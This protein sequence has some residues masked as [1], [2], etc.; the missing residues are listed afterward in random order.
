MWACS[1][2]MIRS[3]I[4]IVLSGVTAQRVEGGELELLS[5]VAGDDDQLGHAKPERLDGRLVDVGK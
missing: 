4:W 1:L 3:R 5:L 2:E